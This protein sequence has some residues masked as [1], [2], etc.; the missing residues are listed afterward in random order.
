MSS[1]LFAR[2]PRI[3][4]WDRVSA[5]INIRIGRTIPREHVLHHNLSLQRDPS[6]QQSDIDTKVSSCDKTLFESKRFQSRL[7]V[8]QDK[9]RGRRTSQC[10]VDATT[11]PPPEQQEFVA[12]LFA[13]FANP[14][15]QTELRLGTTVC[16]QLRHCH[17][18][19]LQLLL[20][21]TI[22]SRVSERDLFGSF[23][24]DED[25]LCSL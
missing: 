20:Q 24:C 14:I 13:C 2:F 4:T 23:A 5:S 21:M 19:L 15:A 16:R 1:P 9:T 22:L 3:Q 17:L 25:Q 6:L 8:L 10:V 18:M 11:V 12:L 7:F